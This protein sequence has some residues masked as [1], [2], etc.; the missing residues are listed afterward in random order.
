MNHSQKGIDLTTT[1]QLIRSSGGVQMKR[2]I[3]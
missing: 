2:G 1:E 3:R